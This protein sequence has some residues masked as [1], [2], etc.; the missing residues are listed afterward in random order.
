MHLDYRVCLADHSFIDGE[1]HTLIP[2]VYGLCEI[3][4]KGA[5]TYSGETFIRLR[6]GKHDCST[7][8]T[9][10]HDMRE[11]FNCSQIKKNPILII[12]TDGA[13]DET[14]WFPKTL[15]TAVD[16]FK[17]LKLDALV[18]WSQRTWVIV[19]SY[20]LVGKILP[21]NSFGNH[22]DSA[23]KTND[24][25]LLPRCR[26]TFRRLKLYGDFYW[27]R[28]R[29][30]NSRSIMDIKTCTTIVVLLTDR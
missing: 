8:Y 1:R 27:S 2:P 28:T 17:N 23:G 11:L 4:S 10:A 22:L 13:A 19:I 5:V 12:E 16:L 20:D 7:A 29:T 6:S 26:D 30:T 9:N 3:S 15:S 25:D 14:P 24:L 18:Q 21:H